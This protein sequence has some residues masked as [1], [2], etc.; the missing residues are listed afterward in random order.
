[1]ENGSRSIVNKLKPPVPPVYE[2]VKTLVKDGNL[3]QEFLKEKPV[4]VNLPDVGDN[5]S[6]TVWLRYSF[7]VVQLSLRLEGE[8]WVIVDLR[9]KLTCGGR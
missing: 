7:A 1:M 6:T 2:I 4:M 3:S 8:T 9:A 5:K